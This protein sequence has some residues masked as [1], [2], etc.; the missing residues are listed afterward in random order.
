MHTHTHAPTHPPTRA[1]AP[2]LAPPPGTYTRRH[3][4]TYARPPYVLT[5]AVLPRTHARAR[6][7]GVGPVP[8]QDRSAVS[9]GPWL[10]PAPGS[11]GS[12]AHPTSSCLSM[13]GLPQALGAAGARCSPFDH[14]HRPWPSHYPLQTPVVGIALALRRAGA[15]R[16]TVRTSRGR[17][18]VEAGFRA[19]AGCGLPRLQSL[20][21]CRAVVPTVWV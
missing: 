3:A 5:H 6:S 1:P 21:A 10:S 20:R 11:A 9:A 4:H 8:S 7:V 14:V 16:R 17:A 13:G 12:R 18:P 15:P 2:A 19:S